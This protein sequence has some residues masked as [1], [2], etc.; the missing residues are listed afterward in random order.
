M[1]SLAISD[2][3]GRLSV[4]ACDLSLSQKTSRLALSRATNSSW[5]YT[6]Q[7]PSGPVPPFS[8]AS[9]DQVA[10]RSCR[11]I[12][13]YSRTDWSRSSRFSG[14]VFS[15]KCLLVRRSWIQIFL[16]YGVSL[17]A[18]SVCAGQHV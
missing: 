12:G 17:A 5:S 3:G 6:R 15:V 7:R 11:F 2:G 18:W 4:S 1:I 8:S 9:A 16:V 10:L 14:L 13:L